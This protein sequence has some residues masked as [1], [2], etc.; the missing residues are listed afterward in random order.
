MFGAPSAW[1]ARSA[2]CSFTGGYLCACVTTPYLSLVEHLKYFEQ[3]VADQPYG[4]DQ[5]T[6]EII[7]VSCSQLEQ[8]KVSDYKVTA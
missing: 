8:C 2:K 5:I 1:S 7:Y 6:R 3:S 4:L